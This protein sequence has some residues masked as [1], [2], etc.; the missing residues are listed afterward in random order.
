M[1]VRNRVLQ[2][3]HVSFGRKRLWGVLGILHECCLVELYNNGFGHA[4]V[5]LF[6]SWRRHA[7]NRHRANYLD[8]PDKS[9]RIR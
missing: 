6:H 3:C 9:V 2:R 4:L 1:A 8:R 5:I 7:L